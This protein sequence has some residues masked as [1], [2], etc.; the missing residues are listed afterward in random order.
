MSGAS[1]WEYLIFRLLL[2][3]SSHCSFKE[4]GGSQN[5]CK[6]TRTPRMDSGAFSI[7]MSTRVC[8]YLTTRRREMVWLP[9]LKVTV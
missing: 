3:S 5:R 6:T 7:K 8:N 1:G 9:C 4:E 2:S